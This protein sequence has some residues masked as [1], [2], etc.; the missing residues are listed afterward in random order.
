MNTI[1][2]ALNSAIRRKKRAQYEKNLY[3]ENSSVEKGKDETNVKEAL[4]VQ[5]VNSQLGEDANVE[6]LGNNG[7]I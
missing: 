5:N 6:E 4:M 1:M 2:G 3:D 7:K